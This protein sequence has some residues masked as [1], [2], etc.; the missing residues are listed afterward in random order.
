MTL[1]A[2]LPPGRSWLPGDWAECTI[3]R[4]WYDHASGEIVSG[5]GLGDRCIVREVRLFRGREDRAPKLALRLSGFPDRYFS[6]AS[7]QKVAPTPDRMRAPPALL[8]QLR[9][10]RARREGA[11]R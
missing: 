6:A 8:N 9:D 11:R 7:F 5:P 4:Q 10:L 3:G 1:A 2:P